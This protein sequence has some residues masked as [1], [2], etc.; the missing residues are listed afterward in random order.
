M[1]SKKVLTIK[2]IPHLNT[3]WHEESGLVFKSPKEL[4]IIGTYVDRKIVP[5]TEEDIT[6]CDKYKFKYELPE[7]EEVEEE[8]QEE[9]VGSGEEEAEEE[10]AGSGEEETVGS[11]EEEVGEEE[12]G[13]EVDGSGEEDVV[14]SADEEVVETNEEVAQEESK[15]KETVKHQEQTQKTPSVSSDNFQ[16]TVDSLLNI[17]SQTQS[18]H[19]R[20]TQNLQND[21]AKTKQELSLTKEELSKLQDEYNKMKVKFDGIKQLFAI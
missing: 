8:E 5:L 21:L 12:V 2:K 10:V 19:A 1:A 15:E 7:T 14:E 17:W 9:V 4:V 13:E 3:V 16:E 20:Q 6:K 11:G 18:A